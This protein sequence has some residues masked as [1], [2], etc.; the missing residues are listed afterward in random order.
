MQVHTNDR[1][2]SSTGQGNDKFFLTESQTAAAE[3]VPRPLWQIAK[4]GRA[5][6]QLA[7]E[8]AS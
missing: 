5:H 8:S 2:G 7:S 6:V 1:P 4:D 3:A